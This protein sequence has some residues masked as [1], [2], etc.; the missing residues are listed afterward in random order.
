MP[1][2]QP[3]PAVSVNVPQYVAPAPP[4]PGQP[5]VTNINVVDQNTAYVS[6]T[7]SPVSGATYYKVLV[8]G[9]ER[10]TASTN[11]ATLTLTPGA[12]YQ[13]QIVAC[14]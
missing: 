9:Y 4:T 6:L 7:W 2:S 1:C 12:T 8:N 5:T 11:S 3:G 10:A 13:V 14:N